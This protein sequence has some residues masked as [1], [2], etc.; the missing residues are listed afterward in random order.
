MLN[1]NNYESPSVE[2]KKLLLSDVITTSGAADAPTDPP[3]EEGE[4]PDHIL[5]WD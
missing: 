2:V 4:L 1:K 5:P 3:V